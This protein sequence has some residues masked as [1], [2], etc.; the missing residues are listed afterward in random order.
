M[1]HAMNRSEEREMVLAAIRRAAR[2]AGLAWPPAKVAPVPL[3]ELVN[4]FNL[5][6][7]EVPMLCRAKVALAFEKAGIE[8]P[9]EYWKNATVLAG[10]LY[11]NSQG[12][13]ILVNRDDPV[14]RRR[15]SAAHE[16]G[17][18]LLHFR[19]TE[20][21][22]L[23]GFVQED[24]TITEAD[25]E[26]DLAA[27]ERQANLFAAELLMPEAVCR[28]IAKS[29]VECGGTS[30]RYLEHKLAG[31]LLVSHEAAKW[32]ARALKFG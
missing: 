23:T 13:Y 24:E 14:A 18:F 8:P 12:G 3:R 29:A 26:A 17:H 4:A 21:D 27:M 32:R 22:P 10:F 5:A 2:Q 11:A 16:L 6:H 20:V 19:P 1:D 7:D 25:E 31:A 28:E 30:I 9:Q 15:F